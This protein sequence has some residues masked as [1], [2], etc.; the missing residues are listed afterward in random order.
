M[1]PAWSAAKARLFAGTLWGNTVKIVVATRTPA[2][3]RR[4]LH[5]WPMAGGDRPWERAIDITGDQPSANGNLFL[6]LNGENAD[7]ALALP[8]PER[9][10]RVLAQFR[11]DMPDLVDEVLQAEAFAWP[12]QDWVRGSFGGP[13]VGGGWMLREWMRP[14]G[15]IHFAGD[16]TTAKTGWVEGAIESGLRAA[17]QIDPTAEAEAGPRFL[18]LPG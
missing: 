15:R 10:A 16:F 12:E 3:L 4:N 18:P 9:A 2:W 6:Y 7:A 17:R 8:A 14:E 13:P 1:R 5:G 11:A